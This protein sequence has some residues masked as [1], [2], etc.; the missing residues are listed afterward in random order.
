MGLLA[1]L[2]EK[3]LIEA[4]RNRILREQTKTLRQ[5]AKEENEI[6]AAAL[7]FEKNTR[8]RADVSLK[9]YQTLLKEREEYKRSKEA[10][11]EMLMKIIRPLKAANVPDSLCEQLFNAAADAEVI[12]YDN[13]I[14]PDKLTVALKITL[15]KEI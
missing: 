1:Y 6:K 4:D 12:V 5:N 9:E 3:N 2:D 10:Y 13:V 7:E 15:K 11:R 14:Q 8:D